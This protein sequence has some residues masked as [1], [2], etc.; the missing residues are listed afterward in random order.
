MAGFDV[1]YDTGSHRP[2]KYFA[3]RDEAISWANDHADQ[4]PE[5]FA[6]TAIYRPPNPAND[7]KVA[8]LDAFADVLADRVGGAQD[9]HRALEHRGEP[10]GG[11]CWRTFTA[12]DITNMIS[13]AARQ[14]GVYGWKPK[15]SDS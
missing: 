2:R 8:T 10:V 11:E 15:G 12:G 1:Y 6:Q 3:D 4:N 14:V 5:V 13:D 7:A 9:N